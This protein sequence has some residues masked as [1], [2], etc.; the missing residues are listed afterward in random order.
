MSSAIINIQGI[1]QSFL[2]IFRRD[3]CL[4]QNITKFLQ[5]SMLRLQCFFVVLPSLLE[6]IFLAYQS[7]GI[8]DPRHSVKSLIHAHFHKLLIS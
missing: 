1:V 7:E 2:E 3:I 8:Q 6:N 5:S 4:F